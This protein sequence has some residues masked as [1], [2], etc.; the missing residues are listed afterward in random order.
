MPIEI[1]EMLIRAFIGGQEEKDPKKNDAEE[2]KNMQV[3]SAKSTL[4]VV[5]ETINREKER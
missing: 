4:A 5:K 2:Q 1:R 3:Q